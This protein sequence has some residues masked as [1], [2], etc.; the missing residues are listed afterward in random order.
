MD[1]REVAS[2]SFDPVI[3]QYRSIQVGSLTGKV[4]KENKDYRNQGDIQ[5]VKPLISYPLGP[6]DVRLFFSTARRPAVYRGC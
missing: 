4:R 2:S 3:H 5:G 1:Y 6:S